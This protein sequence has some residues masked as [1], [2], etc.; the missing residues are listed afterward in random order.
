MAAKKAAAKNKRPENQP[1]TTR[2]KGKGGMMLFLSIL[3][4]LL[5]GLSVR[6][7]GFS[8]VLVRTDA[9]NDTLFAGDL[10]LISRI[11][12]PE[13]GNIVLSGALNGSA[14]RRVAGEPGDTAS[15]IGGQAVRNSMPLYEPYAKGA[16][17]WE[18]PETQLDDDVYLLL[19]DNRSFEGALVSRGG[20]A[21]VARAVIWP[22]SRAGFL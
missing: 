2:P 20:I 11:A 22:P 5:I 1:E 4:A 19:P 6:T 12:E 15:V 9:M 13:A 16:P 8:L 10:V 17:Q 14:F 18:I 7:F 21:G 3:A